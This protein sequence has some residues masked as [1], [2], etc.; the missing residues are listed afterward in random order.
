MHAGRIAFIVMLA[1]VAALT[2]GCDKKQYF[3]DE[4]AKYELV[5]ASD[6]ELKDDVF[7]VKDGAR[8]SAV[9]VPEGSLKNTYNGAGD[10]SEVFWT[11]KDA[12]LIPT[13]YEGEFLAY[14]SAYAD[15][16]SVRMDRFR[17]D[18]NVPGIFN[19][20]PD[21]DGYLAFSVKGNTVP[22]SDASAVLKNAASDSI[23]IVSADGEKASPD[24]VDASGVFKS[25]G[26]DGEKALTFYAG[27][28]YQSAKLKADVRMYSYFET[29]DLGEGEQT[30][31]SY[32]KFEM[33]KGAKSGYYLIRGAGVFRYC[34]FR[35]GEGDTA[36]ENMNEP[37]YESA[38]EQLA[39]YSQ[40]FSIDVPARTGN[41]GFRVD[42]DTGD[43]VDEENVVCTLSSPDGT[44]YEM[45]PEDGTAYVSVKTAI[46]GQ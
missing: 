41:L 22:G 45:Q 14:Q 35:K 13:L 27:T 25:G 28:A 38:D 31:K 6:G 42:Y 17:D 3:V 18:G 16:G 1:A 4:N 9:H 20:A 7:Y 19:M 2:A 32:L 37:F 23:R 39:V 43:T 24:M 30:R 21:Q 44:A 10:V 34:A 5:E 11:M 40:Q 15:I 12:S 29:Y 8:F 36:S 46:A 26:K 33:P